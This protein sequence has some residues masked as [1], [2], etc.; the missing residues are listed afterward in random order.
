MKQRA[1]PGTLVIVRGFET[2]STLGFEVASNGA[3]G[4]DIR[5]GF[6]LITAA[7]VA[8]IL[9]VVFLAAMLLSLPAP[10]EVRQA[11]TPVAARPAAGISGLPVP[12]Q[13]GLT[14]RT[15]L[16]LIMRNAPA[17][18]DCTGPPCLCDARRQ[19]PCDIVVRVEDA[20]G[21]PIEGA[22]IVGLYTDNE[23]RTTSESRITD[24]NGEALFPGSA[25]EIIFEVQYPVGV[26][27]CPGS[28]PRIQT[29]P[30]QTAV[31]FIGCR[32]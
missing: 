3:N 13:A 18:D 7:E 32:L 31:R 12:A 20:D 19:V 16:P 24:E 17:V 9:V 4:R 1:S 22:R 25:R 14:H 15:M 26:L 28:P 30:G 2:R 23:D 6:R 21:N 29:S 10:S 5:R 27:P 11:G 8:A